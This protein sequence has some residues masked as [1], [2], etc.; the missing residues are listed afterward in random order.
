MIGMI[1]GETFTYLE[2]KPIFAKS[3]FGFCIRLPVV[4]DDRKWG[5]YGVAFSYCRGVDMWISWRNATSIYNF[6]RF[7][8]SFLRMLK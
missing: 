4:L 6:G 2:F 5:E 8:R 3:S 7:K 1:A